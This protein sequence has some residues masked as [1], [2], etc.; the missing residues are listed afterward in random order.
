MPAA[1]AERGPMG[2]ATAAKR[3]NHSSDAGPGT[4]VSSAGGSLPKGSA[5][6]MLEEVTG[7]LSGPLGPGRKRPAPLAARARERRANGARGGN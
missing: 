7:P 3:D 5:R 1:P 6:G 4:A 2:A